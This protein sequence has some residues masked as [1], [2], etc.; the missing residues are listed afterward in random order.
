MENLRINL[1]KCQFIF[2]DSNTRQ[3]LIKQ[4][5]TKKKKAQNTSKNKP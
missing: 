2:F 1:L 4:D 5:L 3:S